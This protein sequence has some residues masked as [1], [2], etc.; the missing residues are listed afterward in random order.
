MNKYFVYILTNN[1]NKTLYI[2]V[3]NDIERRTFEHR[4]NVR[5]GFAE[6]YNCYKLVYV[7]ETKSIEDA[8]RLEKQLKGWTRA[9][10]EAL[11]ATVNPQW[12]NLM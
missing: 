2:G 9:K 6:K 4:A 7:E 5:N 8:I 12:N 10:K 1:D 3:T 11:I